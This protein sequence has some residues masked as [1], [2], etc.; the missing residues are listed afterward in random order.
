MTVPYTFGTAT[1]S[2]PLSNLDSNF[3]TPI[4]L[5]NTSIYL[6]NTTTTI[7]NLTLTNATISSGNVTISNISV[8]T[9]NVTTANVAT[10]S[11]TGTATIATANITTGNITT[12]TST[13][14]TDSG[15]TSGRVTYAGASGLLSDSTKLTFDTSNL[16]VGVIG[17]TANADGATG[18]LV[19]RKP[20]EALGTGQ[21]TRMLDFAPYYPG[22]DEAVVKASISSGVDTGT[23][24]G[25]LGFMVATGG[26]LYEKIRLLANGNVGIGTSSPSMSLDVSSGATASTANFTSTTTTAYSPTT[27]ASV[28]NAR[29]TVFGGNATSAYT[30]IRFTQSGS[31]ENF[32]GAV[33]SSS[34]TGQFVWGGYNGSAY[35]EWMR[36]DSSGNLG[37]GVTPSAWGSGSKGF[38][39]L[40]GGLWHDNS[41]YFALANNAYYDGT[42]WKYISSAAASQIAQVNG[43]SRFYNAAAGTAGDTATFTQAMTLDASGNLLVGTTTTVSKTTIFGTGN[44]FVSVT[45]NT[46][47]ATQVGIN[48]NPSM[49][50]AEAA[51]NPA[52]AAIYAVDS[53][54]SANIIFANKATGAIGNSLTERMRINAAGYLKVS[55]TGTYFSA[56]S[57]NHELRTNSSS[58]FSTY[59]VNSSASTP[60]GLEIQFTAAAPNNTSQ[61]FCL[62]EDN[63]ALRFVVMANG[64]IKNFQGNDVN[65]SDRREKTN[66]APAKSY[67]NVICAIPVQTFNYIDQNMGEDDGL[68]LGVTAQ[69]VQSVAPELVKETDWGTKEEPKMRLSIYQTDLQYALM[70]CIQEQQALIESLTTRL[71][72]LENK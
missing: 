29:L 26:V 54:Y 32:F 60:Y 56:A 17:L 48:L 28:T 5:G 67:L 70:K 64:G 63:A 37:L 71:T 38:Q 10:L 36:L 11:V 7:G 43:E 2:I 34:G 12:L 19:L 65:L 72:A 61:S 18:K 40:K 59:I 9:A 55:N 1:T 42:N 6:G 23:Q 3:N 69:D 53:S 16:T 44:Q 39:V 25:Q 24:N 35:G 4:T 68:T 49:T 45:S 52:Q 50:A 14:I 30:A 57:S 22:F 13:S 31:F 20:N 41:Q 46:G 8:T 15:L 33:Q 62:A 51:T 27:S 66:F 58:D 21:I 47:G